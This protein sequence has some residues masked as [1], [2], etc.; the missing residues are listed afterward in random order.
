MV[1]LSFKFVLI[2]CLMES[3]LVFSQVTIPASLDTRAQ[4][5]SSSRMW[6]D[7][8]FMKRE[9]RV[10]GSCFM[11]NAHTLLHDGLSGDAHLIPARVFKA[12]SVYR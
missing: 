7:I 12:L 3:I 9:L 1:S 11:R 6:F 2:Y 5:F 4:R 10:W 8:C